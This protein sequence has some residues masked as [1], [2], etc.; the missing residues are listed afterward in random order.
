MLFWESR[1]RHLKGRGFAP[2]F[3]FLISWLGY[4]VR[5]WSAR[6]LACVFWGCVCACVIEPVYAYKKNPRI[7]R[8]LL[9][10]QIC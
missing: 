2:K 10:T 8:V 6:G 9:F 7:Q 4:K 3:T 5:T 1:R